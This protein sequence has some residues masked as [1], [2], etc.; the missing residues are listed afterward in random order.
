MRPPPA[1]PTARVA[2]SREDTRAGGARHRSAAIALALMILVGCAPT[3]STPVTSIDPLVGRWWG[4]VNLGAGPELFYLTINPDRTFVATWGIAW[5]YGT[6]ALEQGQASYQMSPPP[7]EGT[8]R[9]YSSNG[10][11]TLVM[12]DL[13]GSFHAVVTRQP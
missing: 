7:R 13:F 3:M 11:P 2:F 12:D 8:F 10:K 9:Y 1:P 6:I 4:T 5:S